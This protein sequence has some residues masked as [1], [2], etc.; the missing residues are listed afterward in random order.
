MKGLRAA[1]QE[2][3][4]EISLLKRKIAEL[5]QKDEAHR[6]AEKELRRNRE[7][8][9]AIVEGTTDSAY[10]KDRDGRYLLFN[11]QAA[12][13]TGKQATEVIGK[14]DTFLFPP[15]EA[16]WIMENDRKVMEKGA[17]TTYEETVT[18]SGE[19]RT[20]LSTKG[21]VIDAEGAVTGIF[22][23]AR[24]ITEQKRVEESEKR[25]LALMDYNPSLIF[26]KDSHGRYIY[27]N[28]TYEQQFAHS[29]DWRG[30]TDFDLWEKESAE[31]FRAHDAAVL[32]S[33]RL[34]QF[35]ED[36]KDLN[37]KRHC[38]LCY[39]FPFTDA[40]GEQCVGG[41]GIDDTERVIVQ[42]QLRERESELRRSR[43]E[44]ELRIQ[45]R[46]EELSNAYQNL[47]KEIGD[48]ESIEE[49]LRQ[50]QKMEA[51]GTLA[52]GIAHDFNNIL[53]AVI[54][55]TEMA[56][57][58]VKD[59]PVTKKNL[60]R[61]MKSALRARDL[62]RQ[63][64]AFSRRTSHDRSPL[65]LTP[66][67]K[68][69]IQFLKA[70]IPSTVDIR[71]SVNASSDTV[72]ASP[73]E[74]QQILMNLATNASSAMEETGGSMKIGLNDIDFE[75]DS[76]VFGSD[77]I[78]G[79]YI[80]LSVKDTGVGMTPEVMRRVFDPFF[81][82]RE[83]GKGTGM[84]LSVVHGIV[85]GLQGMIT[86]ESKPGEGTTFRVIL[87]KAKGEVKTKV[88]RAAAVP[89]GKEKILFIDDEELLSEL[90]KE[91]LQR[92]GYHVTAF[93]DP[94]EALKLFSSD[95]SF[96][97][98]V[99]TDQAMPHETGTALARK[100]LSL[101]P[102]IPIILCTGHGE[103]ITPEEAGKMGIKKFLMKP[104]MRQELAKAVRLV[105]PE[106]HRL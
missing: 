13:L 66:V 34:M 49:Q 88:P 36:S 35:L 91:M 92:L 97:D 71:F 67:V 32:K 42:E 58:D 47:Q 85:K 68:E 18:M 73:I 10:V 37:G 64:L 82:T 76:P 6:S 41:I 11:T 39:K 5:E 12:L 56:I 30:K 17:V 90:G 79:E 80:Q 15:G 22:G 25:L 1:N 102:D 93:T 53:A 54:G 95:P 78:A 103:M 40:N 51:I 75:P 46:T 8:L 28:K 62:V 43:D 89:G 81:T 38:W 27:L 3:L 61:V 72:L 50:S 48:R 33:G 14:D 4:N 69:T 98:L 23:L 7:L 55:F 65:S 100:L 94:A 96:F 19:T 86:V 2:L 29:K 44:L 70:S 74:I 52:G 59:R 77:I 20:F 106:Q 16:K 60:Q 26:L 21:S 45:E 83:T 9:R 105:L 87:P 57:D 101:R 99:I 84:G 63:I 24:D 31:L 104:L